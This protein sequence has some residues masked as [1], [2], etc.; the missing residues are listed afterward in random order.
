[1]YRERRKK[2]EQEDEALP[3][4]TLMYLNM[5][6]EPL[7][8]SDMISVLFQQQQVVK[9]SQ[10]ASSVVSAL[11]SPVLAKDASCVRMNVS[12][13]KVSINGGSPKWMVYSG[14]SHSNR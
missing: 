7:H 10:V 4:D 3:K 2:I 1:M 9:A 12:E 13:M 11:Q 6:L 5:K 8:L 14:K